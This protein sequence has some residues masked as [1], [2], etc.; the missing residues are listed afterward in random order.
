MTSIHVF[1]ADGGGPRAGVS[2]GKRSSRRPH[3]A[4][5]ESVKKPIEPNIDLGKAHMFVYA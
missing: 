4:T 3:M 2:S 5:E 1:F